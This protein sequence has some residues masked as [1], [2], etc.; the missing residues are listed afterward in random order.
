MIITMNDTIISFVSSSWFCDNHDNT[1]CLLEH[2]LM[3]I[4]GM[5]ISLGI[6][7]CHSLSYRLLHLFYNSTKHH[8]QY[9]CYLYMYHSHLKQR[10]GSRLALLLP[11]NSGKIPFLIKDCAS[12]KAPV[13]KMSSIAILCINSSSTQQNLHD[14]LHKTSSAFV[15]DNNT[16]DFSLALDLL[17]EIARGRNYLPPFSHKNSCPCKNRDILLLTLPFHSTYILLDRLVKLP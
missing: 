14:R 4:S 11:I 2:Q 5:I 15:F 9:Q 7:D 6:Y 3:S 8:F 12:D 1:I 10:L 16:D 13:I 17:L